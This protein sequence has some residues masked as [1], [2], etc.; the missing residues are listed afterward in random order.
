MIVCQEE[1]LKK[2]ASTSLRRESGELRWRQISFL[3][4]FIFSFSYFSFF[5]P[6]FYSYPRFRVCVFVCSCGFFELCLC[7]KSEAFRHAKNLKGFCAIRKPFSNS[8]T[9]SVTNGFNY[10]RLRSVWN[11]KQCG[12][13]YSA[14]YPAGFRRTFLIS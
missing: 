3:G 7:T 13:G 6:H 1:L 8:K 5:L 14:F 9:K 12:N 2:E 4:F 10:P 11:E